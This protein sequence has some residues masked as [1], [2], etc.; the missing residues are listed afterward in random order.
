MAEKSGEI[1]SSIWKSL[2]D[3][4]NSV[5]DQVQDGEGRA[6][7]GD[8]F[9]YKAYWKKLGDVFKAV[10]HEATKLSLAYSKPPVPSNE[11]CESL[12]ASVERTVLALLHVFSNLPKSAGL[13][14]RKTLKSSVRQLVEGIKS[15]A[16]PIQKYSAGSCEQLQNTGIVWEESDKFSH[17]PQDNKSAVLIVIE[18]N[19]PMV[20]DAHSEL[21]EA[22]NSDEDDDGLDEFLGISNSRSQNDQQWTESDKNIIQ[23]CLGLIKCS[24]SL[25]KKTKSAVKMNGDC[26][27]D[28]YISQLDDVADR[29]ER[30]SPVVDELASCVYPPLRCSV[31]HEKALELGRVNRELLDFLR[32]SHVTGEADKKWLDFLVKANSHNLT[33]LNSLIPPT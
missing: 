20:D 7:V 33:K 28:E 31:V 5:I 17:L 18:N 26:D 4:L 24:K 12:L 19:I 11:E 32:H 27:K 23:Y 21:T 15:L 13:T 30:L 16:E 22:L 29:V 25:L 9:N 10:S 2:L 1:S 14:L 8:D 3:N 6:T